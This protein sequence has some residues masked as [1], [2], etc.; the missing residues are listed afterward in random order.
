[1][2]RVE[3]STSYVELRVKAGAN[4]TFTAEVAQGLH[5]NETVQFYASASD[6]S[7]HTAELGSAEKPL[8]FKRKKNF[9]GF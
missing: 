1:M 7:G 3:G 4:N 8:Q 6:Y 5:K 9:L 2:A